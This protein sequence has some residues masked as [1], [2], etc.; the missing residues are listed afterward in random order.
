METAA[1]DISIPPQGLGVDDLRALLRSVTET[2]EQLQATHVTLH[3]QVARLQREL[4]EANSQLRRSKQLA[5]LGEMAAGI[6]HE[7]RNPLGSIQ[8]YVQL[9]EEDLDGSDEHIGLCRKISK[10]VTGLDAIV[11]DVLQFARDTVIRPEQISAA[12]VFESALSACESLVRERRVC[13]DRRF[14]AALRL[15]GDATLLTQALT[16]L[17]RNAI[18]AAGDSHRHR[19]RLILETRRAVVRCPSGTR[20]SR[21]VLAVQDNG[22]GVTDDVLQRMFNPF[23]TTRATGTGL[24]LAIVHRIIDAHGGHINVRNVEHGGARFELCLPPTVVRESQPT[25]G[26]PV[27]EIS[28]G[29]GALIR[30]A[31]TQRDAAE[32]HSTEIPHRRNGG[33]HTLQYTEESHT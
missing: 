10:A 28:A 33:A 20:Q 4:A 19:P 18:E 25:I 31:T 17:I 8:L 32:Q 12:D 11:R 14:D 7:L 2:T 27:I 6:A 29:E 30:S 26:R 23:F 3:E 15:H 13:I 5:A 16:N 22:P 9:L 24:G 21:L 1:A